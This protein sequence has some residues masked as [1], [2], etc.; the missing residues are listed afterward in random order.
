VKQWFLNTIA[1]RKRLQIVLIEVDI[2]FTLLSMFVSTT[3]HPVPFVT[4]ISA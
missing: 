4:Y 3:E 1:K 2:I